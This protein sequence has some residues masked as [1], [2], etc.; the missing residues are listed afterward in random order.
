MQHYFRVKRKKNL[1]A[2]S[3]VLALIKSLIYVRVE[4]CAWAHCERLIKVDFIFPTKT[5]WE[6]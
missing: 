3:K 4:R 1:G 5:I 2:E 6:E